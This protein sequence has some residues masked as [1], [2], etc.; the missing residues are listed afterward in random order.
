MKFLTSCLLWNP[1]YGHGTDDTKVF[2]W[3]INYRSR[4]NYCLLSGLF[5]KIKLICKFI[6]EANIYLLLFLPYL[7]R[8]IYLLCKFTLEANIY[9]LLFPPDLCRNISLTCKSITQEIIYL[10]LFLIERSIFWK[11]HLYSNSN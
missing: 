10:L 11:F 1:C 9:L 5:R 4:K 6:F 2:I 7:F 8:T 3:T